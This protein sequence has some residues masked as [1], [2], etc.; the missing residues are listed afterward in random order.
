MRISRSNSL[1]VPERPCPHLLQLLMDEGQFAQ[2]VGSAQRMTSGVQVPIARRAVVHAHSPLAR[3]D[4]D[5]LQRS[6]ATAAWRA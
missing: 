2:V 6:R 3:Q 4:A 5:R 1:S